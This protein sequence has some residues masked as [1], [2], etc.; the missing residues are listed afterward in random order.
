MKDLLINSTINNI[1]KYY[2]YDDETLAEIRYGLASLY[3]TI[4]KTIVIFGISYFMGYIKPLLILMALYSILR[5]FGFG[6]H[7][8]KSWHCWI[9]SL[10]TFLLVPYL[11]TTLII[12][13][14]IKICLSI[15]CVILIGIFAPADTEKR[16]LINRKR[17][18]I[19]KI[20][21]ILLTTLYI[22]LF[23]F[24]KD[25]LINNCIFFAIILETIVILPITYK[26]FGLKYNNYK[27]YNPNEKE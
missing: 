19:Y 14:N 11:C 9:A 5:L 21:T 6:V 8:K 22:I 23:T 27:N 17:R 7:A 4:T 16:P 2:N 3:L 18:I 10:I 25:N 26:L 1:T 20:L 13:Y 12:E 15:I 24:I